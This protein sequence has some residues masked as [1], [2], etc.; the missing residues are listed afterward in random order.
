MTLNLTD[1]PVNLEVRIAPVE[2][3]VGRKRNMST[4]ELPRIGSE[5]REREREELDCAEKT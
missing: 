4:S 2:C 1:S 5:E 3:P